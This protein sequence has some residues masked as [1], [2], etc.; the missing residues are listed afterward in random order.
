MGDQYMNDC[1]VMYIKR[2]MAFRIDS[3]KYETS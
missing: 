1:L 2:D 3:A